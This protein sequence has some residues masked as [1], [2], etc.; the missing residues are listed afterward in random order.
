MSLEKQGF[1]EVCVHS[2]IKILHK[3]IP[4]DVENSLVFR[5]I[6][7]EVVWKVELLLTTSL[8][9]VNLLHVE[10]TSTLQG[11]KQIFFQ[12]RNGKHENIFHHY[13]IK[14]CI[15]IF[16]SFCFLLFF[17][18][19]KS[20]HHDFWLFAVSKPIKFQFET[21]VLIPWKFKICSFCRV[22]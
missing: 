5:D 12:T 1:P 18:F 4:F 10:T 2:L 22:K 16:S 20:R 9:F 17:W 6:S 3:I 19:C 14:C 15:F 8:S 21:I 11:E 7:L 13:L